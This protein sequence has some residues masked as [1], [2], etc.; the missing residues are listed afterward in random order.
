MNNIFNLPKPDKHVGRNVFDLSSSRV[1]SMRPSVM[2]PV[3]MIHTV[4]NSAYKIDCADMVRTG[5]LQTAAFLRGKQELDWYFLP[6]SQILTNANNIILGRGDDFSPAMQVPSSVP[7][8]WLTSLVQYAC[9]P[10][11]AMRYIQANSRAF[12]T[13]QD[14][15]LFLKDW[16]NVATAVITPSVALKMLRL[17][18]YDDISSAQYGAA[19]SHRD[20]NWI[21]ADVFALL[22][23]CG[24]GDFYRPFK[25]IVD[26]CVAE[27][28]AADE[29]RSAIDTFLRSLDSQYNSDTQL[30]AKGKKVNILNLV[31]YQKIW[32][33]YYR[34]SLNDSSVLYDYASNTDL[35]RSSAA[36]GV[37]LVEY[38]T[39]NPNEISDIPLLTY[40]RPRLRMFK[41]DL[42]CGL[43]ADTQLGDTPTTDIVENG[44]EVVP[45]P[46]ADGRPDSAYAM[47]YVFAMQSFKEMLLRAG[48]RTRDVLKAQFGVESRYI[49]DTYPHY[50]GSFDG[51][52]ELNK[53][54]ATSDSGDYSVGDLAANAFSSINGHTIDFT[55]ND[56][57][58]LVAVLSFVTDPLIN[59]FGTDP[60][61]RKSKQFDF[62]HEEFA[63]LGLSPV[64]SS[65]FSPFT[66]TSDGAITPASVILGYAARDY[67]YKCQSDLVYDSFTTDYLAPAILGSDVISE[68]DAPGSDSNYVV[69]KSQS[70]IL[71]ALKTRSYQFPD[72]MDTIFKSED[73]GHPEDAHFKV[74]VSATISAILPMPVSGMNL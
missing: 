71:S 51:S 8:F 70:Q 66:V 23:A 67:E 48:S 5:A 73:S 15:E 4:P 10:Y 16:F 59:A 28:Y 22:A 24:Y 3:Y 57:G 42:S 14:W 7:T 26:F 6:Y 2:R 39:S 43:Y 29:Y 74:A 17:C 1:F 65:I 18:V 33:D 63:N 55:C 27:G 35:N 34:D 37:T 68:L 45:V 64:D 62:Y 72:V 19:L 32:K 49:Q 61:V 12:T 13:Q 30:G 31:A 56:Y 46:S 47:R 58:I 60:F 53:V 50:L 20:L 36:G 9:F 52:I 54:S 38:L 11:V 21:G 41:K 25:A 44:D 69:V 40:L